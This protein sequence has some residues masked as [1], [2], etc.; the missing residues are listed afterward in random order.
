MLKPLVSRLSQLINDFSRNSRVSAKTQP[1]VSS[2]PRCPKICALAW[3]DVPPRHLTLP[4]SATPRRA[5][6]LLHKQRCI[7]L[8]ILPRSGSA[9]CPMMSQKTSC[10][11]SL[12]GMVALQMWRL[13]RD[14]PPTVSAQTFYF[15][16]FKT[17]D[18]EQ[19]QSV[20]SPSSRTIP[21][22]KPDPPWI[23]ATNLE[24]MCCASSVEKPLGRSLVA[25]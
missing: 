24:T 6:T 16:R 4:P 22:K 10:E 13:L 7:G 8:L 18:R 5:G 15:S 11:S 23:I 21:L 12:V 19:L 9:I 3:V 1:T 25:R 17:D 20:S 14:P 2:S